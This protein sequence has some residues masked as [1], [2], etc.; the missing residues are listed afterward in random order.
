MTMDDSEIAALIANLDHSDKPTI[1]AAVDALIP[2]AAESSDL[3]AR[4][5]DRLTQSGHKTYWPVAYILGQFPA[6][7]YAVVQTL[8]D[9]LDHRE[10]DIR[11]AMALLLIRVASKSKDGQTKKTAEAALELLEKRRSASA[12][13]KFR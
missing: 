10:P 13:D 7:S 12:E 11:W 1:R 5:S 4:L 2:I 8:L 6:P 9:A 3:R